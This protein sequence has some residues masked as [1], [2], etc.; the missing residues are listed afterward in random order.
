MKFIVTGASGYVGSEIVKQLNEKGC[1]T[2]SMSRTIKD[3]NQSQITRFMLG[4][5]IDESVFKDADILIHCAY[6]F[7]E[8]NK[9][10]SVN[11]NVVGS[12]NLFKIAHKYK[13]KI[14]YISTISAFDDCKSHYGQI[15][16]EIEKMVKLYG[17][18]IIRPGLVYGANCG[19]M[20]GSLNVVTK[21]LRYIIP[22]IGNG[23]FKLYLCH[24]NDLCNL[25]YKISSF[26]NYDNNYLYTAANS[27]PIEFKELLILLAK[28]NSNN[29]F[30]IPIPWFICLFGLR[31]LETLFIKI[32][33]RSDSIISLVF[34]NNAVDFS[35]ANTLIEFREFNPDFLK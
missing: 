30:F 20:V 1:A 11:C 8:I 34:S 23:C 29:P 12:D 9:N 19:G 22:L 24:V 31:L 26:S 32:N 13:V 10:K 25:I 35:L 18:V 28:Y 3:E 21:K 7:K 14:I 6:D 17:G 27:K 16:I 5:I 4:D 33:F 2:V 15:K